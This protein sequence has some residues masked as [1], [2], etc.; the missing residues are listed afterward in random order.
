MDTTI[1]ATPFVSRKDMMLTSSLSIGYLLLSAL[2]IGYKPEQLFLVG[3]FN[4]L[5]Y[6]SRGTRKFIIGFSVFI[7]YWILFDYM[8][9]F[10]NYEYNTVHIG[11]LYQFEKSLFGIDANGQLLTPNE[12]LAIHQ[13]TWMDV[14][15][16]LFYLCWV[17]VP[18]A[19]AAWLFYKD[20]KQ[21]VYFSST[22]LLV[23]LIGFVFYYIYP[24]APPWY[25]QEYGFV[26]KQGTPG[27][28]AG[29]AR[30]DA[31]FHTGIF[32]G[33]YA[34]S[35]NVFAAMPS[36]HSAYP[37]I[38]L[39]YAI[40]SR[41]KIAGVFFA[42]VMAGIWLSAVYTSHHYVTDV[43]AGVLCAIGGIILF[44][45]VIRKQSWFHRYL[46]RIVA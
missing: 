29:L 30:F 24:A 41:M 39:Y 12:F 2:L 4:G 18:L 34:K 36:L 13:Q 17:P 33:L 10:P 27:N 19:F 5:Y 8:K 45:Q 1:T 25:I 26:F 32:S 43:L 23:N 21:F 22:F 6:A 14:A 7:I 42:F 15:A 16:G 31:F 46:T 35:S 9:A 28:T 3:L 37:V 44:Q 20:R 38:T 40:R 11:S